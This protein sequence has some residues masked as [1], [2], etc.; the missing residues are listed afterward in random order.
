VG[1]NPGSKL[2]KA[3]SLGVPTLDEAAFLALLEH[4]PQTP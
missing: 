1:E 3:E 4:G 2:A